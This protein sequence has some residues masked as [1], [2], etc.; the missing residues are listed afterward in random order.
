MK[1]H[2]VSHVSATEEDSH[3]S[4]TEEEMSL[5]EMMTVLRHGSRSILLM[6]I[7]TA[8]IFFSYS[9]VMPSSF[10]SESLFLPPTESDIQH[11][12]MPLSLLNSNDMVGVKTVTID[13]V[14]SMFQRHLESHSVRRQVFSD[15]K[16]HQ[17]LQSK[18]NSEIIVEEAYELFSDSL[19][20][21]FPS[22]I[23]LD[24]AS[25]KVSLDVTASDGALA[26]KV[27]ER[28]SQLAIEKTIGMLFSDIRVKVES[29]RIRLED[30]IN[31]LRDDASKNRL[32]KMS[33]LKEYAGIAHILEMKD[34]LIYGAGEGVQQDK[35][36]KPITY[37]AYDMGEMYN[38]GYAAIEATISV[39]ESRVDDDPF[40]DDLLE[41][42]SKITV[43]DRITYVSDS[44]AVVTVDMSAS[45]PIDPMI[46]RALMV[47]LGLL[48]GCFVGVFY[49]LIKHAARDVQRPISSA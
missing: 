5:I 4:A 31:D 2:P 38:R 29:Q 23:E 20:F 40:I 25:P 37:S 3:V 13:S 24:M 22:G 32:N 45:L 16:I 39:L 48:V 17:H 6:A 8:L 47:I 7:A 18:S 41:L 26:R 30:M 44:G 27:S 28:L 36:R 19:S 21:D 35:V 14:Y 9:S 15:L 42:Q 11:F 12:K 46:S 34:P 43:L 1:V 10:E 49:V 33:R